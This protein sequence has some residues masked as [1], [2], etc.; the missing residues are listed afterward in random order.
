LNILEIEITPIGVGNQNP[1]WQD[2]VILGHHDIKEDIDWN[3]TECGYG[4]EE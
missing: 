3:E 2:L 4:S 1:N